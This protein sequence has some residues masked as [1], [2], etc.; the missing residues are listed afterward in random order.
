MVNVLSANNFI[1]YDI[2][3]VNS[4][5]KLQRRPFAHVHVLPSH[6]VLWRNLSISYFKWR[7]PKRF[8]MEYRSASQN[9][10]FVNL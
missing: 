3:L 2:V 5:K 7:T 6:G 9:I 8:F 1:V 10:Q 4:P